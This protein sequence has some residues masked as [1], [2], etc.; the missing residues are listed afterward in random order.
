[1]SKRQHHQKRCPDCNEW[2]D[3]SL[4]ICNHC[5]FEHRKK[6]KKELQKR[7]DLSDFSVP[8]WQ[9]HPNDPIWLQIVKRPIQ[10]VQ[11]I[12][13]AIVAFFIYLSTACA[14]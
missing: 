9:V 11:L 13:Y 2:F 4:D 8:I 1:M 7:R 6:I 10:V 14:H 3:A 5:G 12:L